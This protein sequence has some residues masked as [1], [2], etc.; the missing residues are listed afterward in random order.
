MSGKNSTPRDKQQ[1]DKEQIEW[2]KQIIREE[3]CQGVIP[4][5]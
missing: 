4:M 3:Y 2:Q 1:E 5:K